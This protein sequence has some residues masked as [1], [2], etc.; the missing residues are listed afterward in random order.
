MGEGFVPPVSEWSTIL[1][2]R[3]LGMGARQLSQL[4]VVSH[5]KDEGREA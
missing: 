1:P 5:F 4:M 3:G 2:L